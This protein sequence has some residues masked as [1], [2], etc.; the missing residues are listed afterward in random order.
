MTTTFTVNCRAVGK[1]SLQPIR[2]KSGRTFMKESGGDPL[3]LFMRTVAFEAA[4]HFKAPL[5][6]P[7]GFVV[8]RRYFFARPSTCY[9]NPIVKPDIDKLDR[10]VFDALTGVA[11]EDDAQVIGGSHQKCYAINDYV[12]IVVKGFEYAEFSKRKDGTWR[13]V[14]KK[15]G[16]KG[17]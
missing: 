17:N 7:W 11:Y 9:E 10:A 13:E 16:K 6:R 2:T 14:R 4:K 12:D 1:G 5:G 8:D 3:V 15:T